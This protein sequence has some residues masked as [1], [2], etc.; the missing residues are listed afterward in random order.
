[1]WLFAEGG[2]A[3]GRQRLV[4]RLEKC[5][6]GVLVPAFSV[7][8]LLPEAI[9]DLRLKLEQSAAEQCIGGAIGGQQDADG[10]EDLADN[11]G[12]SV[13]GRLHE[14]LAVDLGGETRD[15]DGSDILDRQPPFSLRCLARELAVP[16]GDGALRGV[17]ADDVE[18]HAGTPV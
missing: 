15:D 5:G 16:A 14:E 2:S 11:E 7:D 3:H 18:G 6:E 8:R 1:M 10:L 12:D 4:L 9:D 13:P 17:Y